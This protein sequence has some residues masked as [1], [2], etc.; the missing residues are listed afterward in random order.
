MIIKCKYGKNQIDFKQAKNG[1]IIFSL[2]NNVF[3]LSKEDAEKLP[4]YEI[5]EFDID[6]FKK[7]IW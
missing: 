4:L 7:S 3:T 5:E 6:T 2:G 1:K